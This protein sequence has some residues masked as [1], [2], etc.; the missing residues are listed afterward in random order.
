[1]KLNQDCI[2]DLLLYLE[3]NLSYR[4]EININ[5]LSLKD[6]STED[7]LY[8]AEKLSEANFLN[9]ATKWNF[10]NAHIIVVKSITYDG[11]QLLDNI[12][13]NKVWTQ[14]KSVVSKVSSVSIDIISK[15]ASQVIT[16]IISKSMG[17]T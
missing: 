4:K 8:T 13:D 2:R 1:M 17:L 10:E 6:Y 3:E 16:N 14:T 5:K 12:R 11:H 7:L 15:T 9:T